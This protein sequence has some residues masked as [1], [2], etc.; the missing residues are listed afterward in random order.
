MIR[1]SAFGRLAASLAAPALVSA[2]TVQR[3]AGAVAHKVGE[4]HVDTFEGWSR[5]LVWNGRAWVTV[6]PNGPGWR[7]LLARFTR[8]ELEQI[9]VKAD[10]VAR[11]A[12]EF[13]K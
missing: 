6:T 4:L 12:A 10:G 7:A 3:A 1:R 5:A 11:W 9:A 13:L 2:A 8:E